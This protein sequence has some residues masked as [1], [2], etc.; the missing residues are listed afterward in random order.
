MRNK[1]AEHI[2]KVIRKITPDIETIDDGYK[3]W[4][5]NNN[6]NGYVT[7]DDLRIIADHLDELNKEWDGIVVGDLNND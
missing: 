3:V 2:I 6:L 7:A 4:W 1:Y 5:P